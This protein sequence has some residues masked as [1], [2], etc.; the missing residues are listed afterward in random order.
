ITNEEG[1]RL[2]ASVVGFA[3]SG[4]VLVGETAR[5]QAVMNA[6]NTVNSV[7]RVMGRRFAEVEE[8]AKHVLYDVVE[9][10]DGDVGIAVG[11][12]VWTPPEISAR[13]LQKLK[14]AA[15]LHLGEP[16]TDAVITV[17]AYFNDAQR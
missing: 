16:V 15:E 7:K 8:E 6:A 5:R 4:E 11:D 3:E 10:E 2:T 1:Q 17:P 14:R 9:R 12:K 13:I